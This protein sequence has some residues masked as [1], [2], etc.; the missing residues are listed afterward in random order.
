MR[1][2]N[3]RGLWSISCWILRLKY[4]HTSLFAL[5]GNVTESMLYFM[6]L[7]AQSWF[8]IIFAIVVSNIY[9]ERLIRERIDELRSE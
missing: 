7:D 3:T 9:A 1:M 8:M 5:S 4:L 6:G 2:S